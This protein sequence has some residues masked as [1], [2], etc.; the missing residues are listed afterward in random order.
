MPITKFVGLYIVLHGAFIFATLFLYNLVPTQNFIYYGRGLLPD[1]LMNI[2][3]LNVTSISD[4]S[5]FGFVRWIL[6]F[7]LCSISS[8]AGTLFTLA[9]FN[10]PIMNLVPPNGVGLYFSQ[11]VQIIGGLITIGLISMLIAWMTRLG[12]FADRW[13]LA[14]IIGGSVVLAGVGGILQSVGDLAGA[15]GCR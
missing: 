13:A 7:G 5:G 4:R 15:V 1:D 11:G 2:L 10:Y 9:T 14:A 6:S 12:I 8:V 3:T